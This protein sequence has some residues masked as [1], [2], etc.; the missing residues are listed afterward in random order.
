ML[1]SCLPVSLYDEFRAGRRT[2][3]DWFRLAKSLGLDGADISVAHVPSRA[4]RD[5]DDLRDAA[6]D[7]GVRI[8]IVAA[9]SDFTQPEAVER[10]G[11]IE[12]VP[13]G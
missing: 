12:D 2:L 10:A 5:L 3:P 9:Y 13:S 7:A 8:A 6:G 4:P 11:Q 1:L